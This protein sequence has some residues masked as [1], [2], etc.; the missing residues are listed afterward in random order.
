MASITAAESSQVQE[1]NASGR[2]PAVFVHGLWLLASSWDRWA[3]RF[4]QAGYA[5]VAVSWPGDAETVEQARANPQSVAGK[6][7]REIAAHVAEVI[8]ALNGKPIVVGHSFGGLLAQMMAARELSAATAAIDPA[9][10]RGVLPLPLSTLRTALPV[11]SNPANRRRAV[12]LTFEQFRYG[13][14]N[15]LSEQEARQLHESFHVPGTAAPLFEAALANLNPRTAARLDTRAPARG[16]LLVISG[17][18]D[19]T[20][21]HAIAHASFKLERRNPGVTE[22][23]EIPGRGHSLTIDSGWREVADTTL[24]FLGRNA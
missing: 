9:P 10:F 13:W 2:P 5:S 4:E 6:T 24:E 3:E 22:F 18:K 20:V 23:A 21:P 14:A 17:E 1:A 15:A 8:G 19:H 7:L 11:L 12:S 16:P